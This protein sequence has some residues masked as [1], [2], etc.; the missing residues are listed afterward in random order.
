MHA[1]AIK[2]PLLGQVPCPFGILCR[3]RHPRRGL[4][5]LRE[6]FE[7][8]SLTLRLSGVGVGGAYAAAGVCVRRSERARATKGKAAVEEARVCSRTS[9]RGGYLE[10]SE[11]DERRGRFVLWLRRGARRRWR[12][13]RRRGQHRV[14]AR[15]RLL[16]ALGGRILGNP[17]V[18]CAREEERLVRKE[19]SPQVRPPVL[20][21]QR[22]RL[23]RSA[24]RRGRIADASRRACWCAMSAVTQ[25]RR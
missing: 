16:V 20:L 24:R 9:R 6:R 8:H 7:V 12:R 3:P 4:Y 10:T 5:E 18:L 15:T 11:P 14:W 17:R 19:L 23:S 21:A 1:L 25:L 22:F 2:R 13:R